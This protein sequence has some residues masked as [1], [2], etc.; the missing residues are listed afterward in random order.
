MRLLK[1]IIL[2]G[3][4]SFLLYPTLHFF[5]RSLPRLVESYTLIPAPWVIPKREGGSSLR[6]AMV[7]DVLHER[8]HI[9]G[10]AWFRHRHAQV[11][12]ELATYEDG[13]KPKDEHYFALLDD[14][15]VD[16]DRLGKPA[17]GI[18]IL[19]RKLDLQQP[20]DATGARPAPDKAYYTTYANLGT[21]LAHVHLKGAIAKD[22]T[23]IA[24]LREGLAF[25]EQ[26]MQVNPDAHFG[27]ET[28]QAVTLRYLLAAIDHPELLTSVDV[29]GIPWSGDALVHHRLH[30]NR[31]LRKSLEDG[32]F[33]I[34]RNGPRSDQD[35][36]NVDMIRNEMP[37]IHGST[38]WLELV[39]QGLISKVPP[40]I[41]FDEPTLGFIGIWTLGSGA[42]PHF[43]L[44]FAHMMERIGQPSIAWNAYERAYDLSAKFWPDPTI[45][46]LLTN[47]CRDRQLVLEQR[48]NLDAEHLRQQHQAELAFGRAEQKAYQTF[49]VEQ[50]VAG[51]DPAASDFYA[52]FF[53]DRA[54]IASDPGNV[55]TIAIVEPASP[56]DV[57]LMVQAILC[58]I[59]TLYLGLRVFTRWLGWVEPT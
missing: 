19:R 23:A 56:M 31:L 5:S 32:N 28:W 37:Q 36:G 30:V 43:A 27:R 14:L 7:H 20:L 13:S 40:S 41:P 16:F 34:L 35:K 22:P 15:A 54:P 8:F 45:Q 4:L 38:L 39:A 18:P 24:G 21:L 2:F 10:E 12:H 50:I 6:L 52:D 59:I 26:S 33:E 58:S 3:L 55:D 47:H 17:E 9:H 42:N 25:I 29:A 1:L 48:L 11:E 51:K 57:V 49:E 53:R 46:T 44:F